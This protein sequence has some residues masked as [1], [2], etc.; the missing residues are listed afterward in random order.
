[1]KCIPQIIRYESR[2]YHTASVC[3]ERNIREAQ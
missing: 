3:K 2:I 1:M